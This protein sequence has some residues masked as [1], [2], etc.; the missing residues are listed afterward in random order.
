MISDKIT[1]ILLPEDADRMKRLSIPRVFI[2][3]AVIILISFSFYL[4]WLIP[5]YMILKAKMPKL[6]QL[7]M[8]NKEK[9]NE[10]THLAERIH[11]MTIK[12][13]EFKQIDDRLKIMANLET[14]DNMYDGHFPGMGG[15]PSTSLSSD[16]TRAATLRELVPMM[17]RTLDSLKTMTAVS[18]RDKFKLHRYFRNQKKLLDATPSICPTKGLHSSPF[19]YRVSPF[20]GKREFHNGLDISTKI[21][22]PV[23]APADGIVS[24]VRRDRLSGNVLVLTHGYGFETVYAH[25]HE[26]LVEKNQEVKRGD[27]VARVGNTGLSTGPHLHYEVHLNGVPTDP[28]KYF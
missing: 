17:H 27:T 28:T 9:E 2:R 11:E 7:E 8:Q 4:S 19:G 21:N 12:I 22:T 1:I 24:S 15:S 13:R 5:H 3:L 14:D 23:I 6:A 10:F 20:T 26:I 25:L 18:K 16:L